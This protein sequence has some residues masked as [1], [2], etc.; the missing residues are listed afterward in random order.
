MWFSSI[1][2]ILF[3]L[4]YC[5]SMD[6][7]IISLGMTPT[8]MKEIIIC[9]FSIFYCISVPLKGFIL[10]FISNYF[11]KLLFSYDELAIGSV[12]V[13]VYFAAGF[14]MSEMLIL[15]LWTLINFITNGYKRLDFLKLFDLTD[16]DE[17]NIMTLGTKVISLIVSIVAMMTVVSLAILQYKSYSNDNLGSI[18]GLFWIFFSICG[19]LYAIPD[20]NTMFN[21]VILCY[22]N[23]DKQVD[24]II[25][26]TS[27]IESK[28]SRSI[29]NVIIEYIKVMKM[30]KQFNKIGRLFILLSKMFVLPNFSACLFMWS[31]ESNSF[32]Q[33][34]I[35]YV[36]F[37]T[38]FFYCIRGYIFIYILGGINS[39]SKILHEKLFTLIVRNKLNINEKLILLLI[40]QDLTCKRIK[41]SISEYGNQIVN[42]ID[43][44]SSLFGTLQLIILAFDFTSM[45]L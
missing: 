12:G 1:L 2:S 32:S 25:N 4:F 30:I 21:I 36:S 5:S 34:F 35:K 29:E 11:V 41:L 22:K 23:L 26:Y 31:L 42:R 43:F 18:I 39:K 8:N 9:L 19:P 6:E 40:L 33:I 24:L 44:I 16:E 13:C 14:A 38:A 7:M 27:I 17:K 20:V 15:R 28:S 37:T 10:P 45:I 3:P